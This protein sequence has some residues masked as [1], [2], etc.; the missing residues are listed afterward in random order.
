[1][2][3]PYW[4]TKRNETQI[5]LVYFFKT[6]IFPVV[7]RVDPPVSSAII[8]TDQK[9]TNDINSIVSFYVVRAIVS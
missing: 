8:S 6:N 7:V 4:R 3:M 1:M 5:G 9:L 2:T